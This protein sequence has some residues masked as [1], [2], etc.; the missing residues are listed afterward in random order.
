[1]PGHFSVKGPQDQPLK[2]QNYE[3]GLLKVAKELGVNLPSTT[4]IGELLT[5]AYGENPSAAALA[6]GQVKI[7]GGVVNFKDGQLVSVELSKNG[8]KISISDTDELT[9]FDTYK[10]TSFVRDQTGPGGSMVTVQDNDRSL[11]SDIKREVSITPTPP[12]QPNS[13]KREEV[14]EV[15]YSNPAVDKEYGKHAAAPMREWIN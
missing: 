11:A 10:E 14:G 8:R 5:K 7:D 2:I 1:M 3:T 15:S 9:G 6:T 13:I 12:V 4:E